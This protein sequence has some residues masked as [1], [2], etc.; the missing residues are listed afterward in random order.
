MNTSSD[1][2]MSD[3]EAAFELVNECRDLWSNADAWQ[4]HLIQGACRLTGTA[5]GHYNEQQL[6]PDLSSTRILEETH[7]GN[8]RDST[9]QAQILRVYQ[10]HP[11]RAEYFPRCMHLAGRA[12]QGLE[13]TALR[14]QLRP[15]TEWYRSGVYN[16][17]R[18]PAFVDGLILSFALNPSTGSVVMLTTN[19]DASDSQPTPRAAA[20]LSLLTRQI[21]PLVGSVLTTRR[22][23]G[24]TGLSPRMSQTL[25]RLLAGD[26]EK[27]IASRLGLGRTT[28]HDYVGALYQHFDVRSRGEL[29]AY[30]LQRK[31]KAISRQ[32]NE[33]PPR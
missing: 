25:D 7:W 5:N 18:R 28:V 22:H 23:R 24:R 10:E 30:F 15:N 14:P 27:E 19:Q 11:N 33:L 1:L 13:A 26:S 6:S 29:M 2:R 8:W 21:A 12:L 4:T 16:A 32:A 20:T 17:Y 9:Q 3:V 31:P